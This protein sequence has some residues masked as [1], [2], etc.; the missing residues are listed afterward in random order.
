MKKVFKVL[1]K[2]LKLY[3]ILDII[4]IF[5]VG[6]SEIWDAVAHRGDNESILDADGRVWE[7]TLFRFSNLFK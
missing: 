2:A 4:C 7:R 5:L 6:L 3:V 1:G